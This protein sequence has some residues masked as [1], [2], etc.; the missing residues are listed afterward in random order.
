M[1]NETPVYD[2]KK[3]SRKLGLGVKPLRR[4]IRDGQLKAKKI[5]KAYYVTEHN[6]LAFLDDTTA[7]E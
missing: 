2:L 1:S 6:L 7:S 3:L 4:Y 5:G